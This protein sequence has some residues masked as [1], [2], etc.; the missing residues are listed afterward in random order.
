MASRESLYDLVEP[1]ERV[2]L[3]G[4]LGFSNLKEKADS[5]SNFVNEP[6]YS[7]QL[8]DPQL[9]DPKYGIDNGANTKLGQNILREGI[10]H[11]VYVSKSGQ[12]EGKRVWSDESKSN[13]PVD[14]IDLATHQEGPADK[15]LD[16][17]L[18]G[19]QHVLV[20]YETFGFN[21][22]GRKGVSGSF[23]AV[24]VDDIAKVQYRGGTTNYANLF[25][26]SQGAKSAPAAPAPKA[27]Q[28]ESS[29]DETADNLFD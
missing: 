29:I 3:E 19:G 17:E 2:V 18:A 6:V 15:I 14:I 8:I 16:A 24:A 9:A 27:D 4:T 23:R 7:I 25:G 1:G 13:R 26:N 20:I 28:P 5:M 12:N 22:N 21:Y 11:G 10:T